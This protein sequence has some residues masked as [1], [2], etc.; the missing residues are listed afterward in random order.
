MVTPCGGSGLRER[1]KARTH[2]A[3][4][5]A[6][7][8]LFEKQGYDATTVEDIA[9]AADVS[10]RTFFRYFESKLDVVMAPKSGEEPKL[11]DLLAA[12]PADESPVEAFRQ[13]VR[14]EI[15]GALQDDELR[16]RQFRLVMRTPSL[17]SFAHEHFNSHRDGFARVFAA[18]MALPEDA[19]APQIMATTVSGV[20]WTVVD[21]WVLEGTGPEHF[22]TLLDEAFDLLATG[23]G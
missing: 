7:I 12:R 11:E 17:R 16:I 21:R 2:E 1:K 23:L 6:A 5:L 22:V 20:M 18:R 19:L 8:D 13:V 3:I 14:N 9:A 15:A 10:Q 4:V